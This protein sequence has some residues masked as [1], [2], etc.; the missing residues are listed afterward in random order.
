MRILYFPHKS[1]RHRLTQFRKSRYECEFSSERRTAGRQ[2]TKA[3]RNRTSGMTLFCLTLHS[4]NL[5]N[6][7]YTRCEK[8]DV[9]SMGICVFPIRSSIMLD[10]ASDT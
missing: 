2:Q 6:V 5:F 8:F 9:F 10:N 3:Q 1:P 4:F 7:T